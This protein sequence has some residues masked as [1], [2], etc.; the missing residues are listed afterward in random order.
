MDVDEC[1]SAYKGLT[2][3]VLKEKLSWFPIS[4]TR[5]LKSVSEKVITNCGLNKADLFNGGTACGCRV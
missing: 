1:V 3:T 4:W 5:K 2:K